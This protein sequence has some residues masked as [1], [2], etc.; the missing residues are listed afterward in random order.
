MCSLAILIIATINFVILNSGYKI[1]QVL[2]YMWNNT[3]NIAW[4]CTEEHHFFF[5]KYDNTHSITWITMLDSDTDLESLKLYL[6]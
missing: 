4:K 3:K 5:I 6:T 1:S 2:K